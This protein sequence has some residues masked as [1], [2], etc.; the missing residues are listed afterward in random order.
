VPS[1][2]YEHERVCHVCQTVQSFIMTDASQAETGSVS[3]FS[4]NPMREF[5]AVSCACPRCVG[6]CVKMTITGIFA[7]SLRSYNSSFMDYY[8]SSASSTR[9]QGFKKKRP[10]DDVAW[11]RAT[12]CSSL[13]RAAFYHRDRAA[14][15]SEYYTPA[16]ALARSAS[17]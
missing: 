12:R 2:R 1:A 17:N 13:A 14:F 16:S 3:C 5:A 7:V 6:H 10:L 8:F 15:A 11:R 4:H 9:T